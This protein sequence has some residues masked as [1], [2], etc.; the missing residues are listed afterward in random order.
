MRARAPFLS[1]VRVVVLLILACP[2]LALAIPELVVSPTA[3]VNSLTLDGAGN[4]STRIVKIAD[5]SLST[6]AAQGFTLSVSSGSLTKAG[7]TPIPFQVALV[8]DE[9]APPVASNFT[10]PSGST[11]LY[12]TS[13]PGAL[14][15]DLYI[16]YRSADLQDPGTYSASVNLSIVDN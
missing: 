2:A 8:A 13:S 11:L 16:K 15:L 6:N 1:I 5:L 10:V 9:A 14:N 3:G 4:S 12:S 7:G